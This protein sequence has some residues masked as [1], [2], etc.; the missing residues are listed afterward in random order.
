MRINR[1]LLLLKWSLSMNNSILN[2]EYETQR[3]F[4]LVTKKSK[5]IEPNIYPQSALPLPI[6]CK[7]HNNICGLQFDCSKLDFA[8]NTVHWL[9]TFA[10]VSTKHKYNTFNFNRMFFEKH[11]QKRCFELY[12]FPAIYIKCL[13][14]IVCWY[15]SQKMTNLFCDTWISVES[16][17][18]THS[19]W[20]HRFFPNYRN[21]DLMCFGM[22]LNFARLAQFI[23]NN[24]DVFKIPSRKELDIPDSVE[25]PVKPFKCWSLGFNSIQ[26]ECQRSWDKFTHQ[27]NA[28]M[29]FINKL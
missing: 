14:N 21:S 8:I 10:I 17:M 6:C 2:S 24:K 9:K 11:H 19:N 15:K 25:L 18:N 4:D 23:S 20:F 7:T 27:E 28:F 12:I 22:V 13:S 16:L 26:K 1:N 5:S 29:R 3:S